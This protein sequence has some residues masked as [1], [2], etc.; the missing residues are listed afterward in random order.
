M[1][2]NLF[3]FL[4]LFVITS[5]VISCSKSEDIPQDVEINDFIW[6]GLN[7]YYKWQGEVPDLSDT[8][9]SNREQLNSYLAGFSDSEQFFYSLLYQY[10]STDRYSWIVDDYVALQNALQGS[11]ETTGLRLIAYTYDDGSENVYVVVRDVITGSDAESQGITRGMIFSEVDGTPLTI[12]NVNTL[13][14]LDSY[15]VSLADF[16]GGNPIANGTVYD[17]IRTQVQENPVKVT[18]VIDEGANQIG[19]LFYNQFVNEFDSDLN[20]A[21]ADF[22]AQGITDLVIDLRYNGGGSTQTALYMASMVTG[23]FNEEIFASQV[24]ND[25]VMNTF[26]SEIFLDRFTDQISATSEAIN[27]LNLNAVYFIVTGS[28]ASASE[29]VIN[30]L[31]PF[32]DVYTVGTL[33]EGKTVGSITLYDSDDYTIDGPNF[34][35]SH[36]WA[37]QP[38]VVE[39]FNNDGENFPA[40][41][42]PDIIIEENPENFGTFGDPTEPLLARTIEFITTGA[43]TTTAN[44]SSSHYP[45]GWNSDM[46]NSNYNNMYVDFK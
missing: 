17:L 10:G 23:Q 37:M 38:I 9:F 25:K 12:S 32:I 44:R 24:W 7:A 8:R 4:V 1:M 18:T 19:Y 33:T 27:S 29:L 34:N 45:L 39:I 21:F 2:K 6:G 31:K 35:S 5:S 15:S 40:G 20:A 16:N 30:G 3:K 46:E 41:I 13:F 26:D 43:R 14:S 28:T 36:N 11:S 22:Q 42:T